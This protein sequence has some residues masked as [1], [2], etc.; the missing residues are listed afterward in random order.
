MRIHRPIRWRGNPMWF[1]EDNKA[2]EAWLAQHCDVVK[3]DIAYKHSEKMT[4]SAFGFLRAT[5]FRWASKISSWCPQLMDAPGV[6]AVGDLHLE[7]FGTWRDEDG[8]L[9][10]GVNDFDE[11][12]TMP[13]ALNLVRLVASI[14][15]AQRRHDDVK[16]KA[17]A[18]AVLE[19]Y[20]EGLDDPQPALLFEGETWLWPHGLPD[21]G[22]P[23]R[24]L[25]GSRR[26]SQGQAASAAGDQAG[27]DRQ[28]AG[29][30]RHG[31]HS[32]VHAPKGQRQPGTAALCRGRLLARRAYLARGQGA[33]AL[34]M[35]LGQ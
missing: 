15:L 25:G 22:E 4:D 1:V 21:K 9:V 34:G 12:A 8:R 30:C 29:R 5:Y 2:Y 26:I 14:Q 18:K 28:H 19:G 17:A 27:A 11:A 24:F 3:R 23:E 10:W 35:D 33:G 16:D 20:R 32:P 7:N 6:L 13:Y 31:H